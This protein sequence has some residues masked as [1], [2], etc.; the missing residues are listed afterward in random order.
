MGV[1]DQACERV[2]PEDRKEMYTVYIERATERFGVTK[3]REIY[4][5]A[6]ASL[7]DK[8]VKD[9]IV[10]YA[11][12]ERK[13][14]EIDRARHLLSYGCQFT[15]PRVD[16]A[17][18]KLWH[19]FEA[20]H[21]NEDTYREMLRLRRSVSATAAQHSV[22]AAAA[23]LI[24]DALRGGAGAKPTPMQALERA[25]A[26]ATAKQTADSEAK[27]KAFNAAEITA[28]REKLAA[29]RKNAEEIELD[30]SNAGAMPTG[31]K[32]FE[33]PHAPNAVPDGGA[34]VEQAA[35]PASVFGSLTATAASG[36]GSSGSAAA[37]P[38]D[39]A[40]GAKARFAG[41][42]SKR[43]AADA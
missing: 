40:L 26:D 39:A 20:A 22:V 41:A 28:L 11:E 31:M 6:I 12:M 3:T 9:M 16:T 37:A 10:R 36:S 42:G 35:L 33:D 15:D 7:P 19:D 1:Y 8:H 18:W 25:A 32:A 27:G 29:A 14:G 13:L 2:A 43:K 17:Y 5:K 23:A 21:G 24:P 34:D 4:E 30:V 38:S